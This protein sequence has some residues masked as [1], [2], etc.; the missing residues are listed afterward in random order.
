MA[1]QLLLS[2]LTAVAG[3]ALTYSPD[4]D[5]ACSVPT[6]DNSLTISSTYS[7]SNARKGNFL[8]TE[9]P[10]T[11]PNTN[12]SE[13]TQIEPRYCD[14]DIGD[15]LWNRYH[16][17]KDDWDDGRGWDNACDERS[18]RHLGRHERQCTPLGRQLCGSAN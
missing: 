7:H 15:Q 2:V 9:S 16:F 10:Q 8:A 5:A 3:T 11:R 4:A 1:L 14:E 13:D 12:T 18:S 6:L 17:D